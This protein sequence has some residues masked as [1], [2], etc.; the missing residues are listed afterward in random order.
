MKYTKIIPIMLLGLALTA[1]NTN[2]KLYEAQRYDELIQK[3]GPEMCHG[4][5]QNADDFALLANAYHRANQADHERIMS[6]KSS[7][8]PSAW[9]EIFQRFKSMKG[10][11]EALRCM[12]PKLK[13]EMDYV[14]LDLDD[15]LAMARSK[16]ESYLVAKTHVLLNS[17]TKEDAVEAEN[18]IKQLRHT[19]PENSHLADFQ[20]RALLHSSENVLV[21]FENDFKYLMPDGFDDEVVN[22]DADELAKSHANF[23]LSKHKGVSYDLIV[24]VV[25]QDVSAKPERTESV[26]FDETLGDKKAVVTDNSQSKSVTIKGELRYFDVHRDRVCFASPF[27]V[28][29]AFKHDYTTVKGDLEACSAAT[30]AKMQEKAVPFPTE[31]S[32]LI[33]AATKLNDLVASQLTK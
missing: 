9:P 16:A 12:K 17:G 11:N 20:L 5:R 18:Y 28:T 3:V 21:K 8:E 4:N 15:E 24:T 14:H 22:F 23:Y 27:E 1:C 7:G 2:K 25:L 6:L 19:S 10:R 31:D 26:T 33:D 29:S 32:M 30:R 13:R